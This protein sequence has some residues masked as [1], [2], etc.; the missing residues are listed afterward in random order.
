VIRAK[1]RK[2]VPS[3]MHIIR[4]SLEKNVALSVWL[5]ESFANQEL[6]KEFL[7]D[8]PIPDMKRFVS[9]LLQTAMQTVYKHEE[10][11]IRQYCSQFESGIVDYILQSQS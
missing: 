9:G 7:I 11:S 6:I 10:E 2:T 4:M 3:F 8:C 5:L 1:E